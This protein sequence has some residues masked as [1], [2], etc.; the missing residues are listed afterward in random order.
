M[1]EV[2]VHGRYALLSVNLPPTGGD[3]VVSAKLSRPQFVDQVQWA[4]FKD[5]KHIVRMM[6]TG[7]SD[8]SRDPKTDVEAKRRTVV[9]HLPLVPTPRPSAYIVG[10]P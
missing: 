8:V 9:T 10:T 7:I 4:E 6:T 5:G 1:A 2:L 3:V